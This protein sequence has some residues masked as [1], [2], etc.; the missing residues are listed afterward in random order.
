MALVVY[1]FGQVQFTV[2]GGASPQKI[3]IAVGIKWAEV[4][5]IGTTPAMQFVGIDPPQYT[6]TGDMYSDFGDG[7]S[8]INAMLAAGLRGVAYPLMR[9]S[10]YLG[11]FALT[12][13][14][15]SSPLL[16]PDGTPKKTTFTATLKQVTT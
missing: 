12:A 10:S 3:D 6:F 9:G 13:L 2:I 11:N 16:N 4:P 1:S 8:E 5:R 7:A 14:N 15:L